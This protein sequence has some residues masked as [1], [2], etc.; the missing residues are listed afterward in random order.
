MPLPETVTQ[1]LCPVC[2]VNCPVEYRHH[3]S[4]LTRIT[5]R[6]VEGEPRKLC[7]KGKFQNPHAFEN[8]ATL[9][10]YIAGKK[11]EPDDARKAAKDILSGAS[12]AVMRISPY[13][14]PEAI[15]YLVERAKARG[16]HL[17]PMGIE[18]IDD[19][20]L[21]LPSRREGVFFEDTSADP[22]AR[23]AI[24]LGELEDT[25]NVAFTELY[26]MKKQELLKL[27]IIGS[28][29]PVARK[30]ADRI[31][32]RLS[33]LEDAFQ[34][35]QFERRTVDLIVNPEGIH[36]SAER[37]T[38]NTL[39]R[40]IR[41]TGTWQKI[42]IT[43]Y[44]NS[45]SAQHLLSRLK[46]SGIRADRLGFGLEDYDLVLEA[47]SDATTANGARLVRWGGNPERSSVYFPVPREL[48]LS[49][50]FNPSGKRPT[51]PEAID[52]KA[53]STCFTAL[54]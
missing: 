13:L 3:G 41:E 25:N 7:E 12:R 30:V 45:R 5:D 22:K 32:P 34:Y 51:T 9:R 19:A 1:G 50:T 36:A 24:V 40:V 4:L 16:Y 48:W 33:D 46:E 20:W 42:R 6:R 43:L 15:D 10:H 18:Q 52:P 54:D 35:A 27:W 2:S 29:S 8:G 26:R 44:W 39:F 21:S 31:F 11:C 14:A 38:E 23:V 17:L 49:G 53:L 37:V 28:D 47:G